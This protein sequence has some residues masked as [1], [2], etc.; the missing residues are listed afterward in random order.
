MKESDDY[1]LSYKLGNLQRLS[2]YGWISHH[3]PSGPDKPGSELSYCPSAWYGLNKKSALVNSRL[4][5]HCNPSCCTYAQGDPM[6]TYEYY[7]KLNKKTQKF[8]PG[9]KSVYHLGSW[10]EGSSNTELPNTS[11]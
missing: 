3:H 8:K 7:G 6:D 10:A 4:I 9:S 11:F 1:R 5:N 2:I